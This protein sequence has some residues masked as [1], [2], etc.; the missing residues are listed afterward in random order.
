MSTQGT[1]TLPDRL[2]KRAEDLAHRTGREVADVLAETIELSLDPLGGYI[3]GEHAADNWSDGEVLAAVEAEMPV[4]DDQRL[5]ELLAAQQG[6]A[7]TLAEEV[8]LR[9]LMHVYQP[10]LLRK[11]QALRE[12]VRRGLRE[13][14]QP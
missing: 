14:P 6:A 12:A 7:L 1:L 8:E 13:P 4:A 5:S 11:A 2:W 10:G 3:E 9:A